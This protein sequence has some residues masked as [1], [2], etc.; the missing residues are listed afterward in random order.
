M[1]QRTKELKDWHLAAL[2]ILLGLLQ[3]MEI[4]HDSAALSRNAVVPRV[5]QKAL[6]RMGHPKSQPKCGRTISNSLANHPRVV[7][8]ALTTSETGICCGLGLRSTCNKLSRQVMKTEA[9]IAV[10]STRSDR[11]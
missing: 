10:N 3:I 7:D 2:P 5:V 6:R 4:S 8:E 9:K 1:R 11:P